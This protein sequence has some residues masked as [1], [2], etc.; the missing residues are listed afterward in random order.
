MRVFYDRLLAALCTA[1]AIALGGL[2]IAM[3]ADIGLRNAGIGSFPWVTELTEYVLYGGTLLGAAWV[4][5]KGGHVRVDALL[6]A[7]PTR[8]ARLAE[9]FADICGF[10]VSVTM[11]WAGSLAVT[12]AWSNN[13]MQFK[14]WTVPEWL[15]LLPVPV[16]CGFLAIEFAMRA[17]R[18]EGI[19]GDT[20]SVLDRPSI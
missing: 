2:I 5:R 11:C 19:V 4:L 1:F 6:V 9:R 12:D 8:M 3:T 7:L 16:G 10:G 20:Y 15:L 13:M 18:V 17:M 14:T